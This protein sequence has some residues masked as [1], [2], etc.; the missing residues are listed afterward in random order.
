MPVNTLS[1]YTHALEQALEARGVDV[2]GLA[3]DLEYK[4]A[5]LAI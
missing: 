2:A 3:A 1:R 4:Q 5:E